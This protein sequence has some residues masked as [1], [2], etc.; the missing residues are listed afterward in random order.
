[1]RL[2]LEAL[3]GLIMWDVAVVSA[4]MCN[5]HTLPELNGVPQM[6]HLL[7]GTD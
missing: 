4:Q 7:G 2:G 3:L 1:M 5:V 6:V